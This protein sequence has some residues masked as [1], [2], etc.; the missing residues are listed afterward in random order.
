MWVDRIVSVFLVKEYGPR[1]YYLG[2][3][4]TYHGTQDMWKYGCKNY[5][6]D[7]V[8]IIERQFR[9]FPK[10]STPIPVTEYHPEL[11]TS[12]LLGIDEHRKYHMLLYMLQ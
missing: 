8:V 7:A 11:D 1:N 9:C 3:D 5:T 12:P 4:Y 6:T 10:V 2:N